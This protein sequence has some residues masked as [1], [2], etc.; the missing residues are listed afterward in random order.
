MVAEIVLEIPLNLIRQSNPVKNLFKDY[1][2]NKIRTIS[3]NQI[4]FNKD[5]DVW[6]SPQILNLII[7]N[8]ISV[9][10]YLLSVFD[11]FKV[12]MNIKDILLF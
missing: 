11:E 10:V 1:K 9:N 12:C 6:R 7:Y 4:K 2:N 8:I 3:L 5:V